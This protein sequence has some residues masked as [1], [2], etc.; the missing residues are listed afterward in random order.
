MFESFKS[1]SPWGERMADHFLVP[2][3]CGS[4]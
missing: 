2:N 3:D 1:E 4:R